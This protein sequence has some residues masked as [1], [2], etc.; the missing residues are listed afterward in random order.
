MLLVINFFF[1]DKYVTSD[2]S[3]QQILFSSFTVVQ[4]VVLMGENQ[5][6]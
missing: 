5:Q 4:F 2:N 1:F 6:L 3:Q